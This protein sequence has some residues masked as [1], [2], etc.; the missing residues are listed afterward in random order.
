MT[1][2]MKVSALTTCTVGLG[3]TTRSA[4]TRC[5]AK[6][7]GSRGPMGIDGWAREAAIV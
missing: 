6:S 2:P 3:A 1:V 7:S 4:S 5:G